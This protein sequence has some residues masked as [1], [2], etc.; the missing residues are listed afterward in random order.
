MHGFA[1]LNQRN[2]A[3]S[4]AT[5]SDTEDA[6]K[7]PVQDIDY[8]TLSPA[9]RLIL[10]Q[11]ILDSVVVQASDE[12]LTPEQIAD[13]ERRASELADG[14]LVTVPWEAVRTRVLNLS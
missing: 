2:G 7:Q 12:L 5:R 10:V 4:Q 11:D 6:M 9:E 8:T 14:K 1:L 13:V 3:S